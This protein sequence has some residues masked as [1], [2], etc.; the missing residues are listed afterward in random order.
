MMEVAV[1]TAARRSHPVANVGGGDGPLWPSD[2][3]GGSF[4]AGV[5]F[6]PTEGVPVA[7]PPDVVRVA[8]V[9]PNE[10]LLPCET[11]P[12]AEGDTVSFTDVGTVP[13]V[14]VGSV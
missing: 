6:P 5:A 13:L 14:D 8:F 4:E 7:G 9:L 12:F 3:S 1:T 11:V 2:G 10:P